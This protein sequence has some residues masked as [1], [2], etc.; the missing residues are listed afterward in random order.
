VP[1][2]ENSAMAVQTAERRRSV[3]LIAAYPVVLNDRG[4]RILTR[5]R[6]A[7]ISEHGAF[8]VAHDSCRFP[9]G[10]EVVASLIVPDVSGSGRQKHQPMRTVV[11]ICRVVRTHS[12]G[13]LTAV[14]LEFLRKLA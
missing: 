1:L 8:V 10:R 14:G 2:E 5:G 6:T 11:Y 12:L 9:E 3:R 4:G 13:P 7:N